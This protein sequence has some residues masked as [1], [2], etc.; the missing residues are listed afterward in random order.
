MFCVLGALLGVHLIN[1]NILNEAQ[2]RVRLNLRSG[3]S[4]IH[5]EIDQIGLFVCMLG[6]G[7]RVANAYGE[8]GSQAAR[9]RP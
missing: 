6:P 7:R 4:V 3:W 9:G 8:P 5:G 2:R 1:R